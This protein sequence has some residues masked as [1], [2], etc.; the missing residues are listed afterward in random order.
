M[1]VHNAFRHTVS[2]GLVIGLLGACASP[3]P[4]QR[5]PDITFSHLHVYKVD[6]AKIEIENRYTAPL[7][8]PHIAHLMPT[9]PDK[10][11]KK[12]VKDRFQAVGRAG[13]LR[14][15]IKDARATETALTLD[16]SLKGRLTRQQSKRYD[17]AVLATLHMRD[18]TGK[19]IGTARA[20]A[21][22]SITARED[23]SLNDREKL[24]FDT[25]NLL[26][27]DFNKVM[28]VNVQSYLSRWLR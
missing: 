27:T 24:W 9:A 12:W 10:A 7:K 5:L 8:A 3:A 2:T 28:E 25:V 20:R 11:L 15:I 6:V 4:T 14:L 19:T 21:E 22:R 13:S 18:G 16:E 1:T 26:M 23:I 17:M